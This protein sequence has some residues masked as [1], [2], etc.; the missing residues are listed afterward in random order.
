MIFSRQST[1]IAGAVALM[2]LPANAQDIT[3]GGDARAF[4]MGG[5][6]IAS[7][8]GN[9]ISGMGSRNNPASLSCGN[10]RYTVARE[11]LS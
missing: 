8:A 10:A 7:L 1:V 11:T 5:A 6:G 9:S 4:A 3:F 2:A